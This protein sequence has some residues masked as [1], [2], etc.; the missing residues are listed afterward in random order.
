M[1]NK[2]GSLERNKIIGRENEQEILK[3]ALA[4]NHAEFIALFGRRR[5]GKSF[6]VTQYFSGKNC[7]FFYI[8]GIKNGSYKKQLRQFTNIISD[9]FYNGAELKLKN[10]WLDTFEMLT[11][12]I[13]KTP[14]DKKIV[15]FMDEFPWMVTRRSGLLEAVDYYWNRF[16]VHDRRIKLIICGS[17]ASWIINNIINNQG[18]LHNRITYQINLDVFNLKETKSYLHKSGIKLNDR[19]ITQIYMVTGG[20]PFYLSK[21]EKGISAA[22]V[23]E[24]L[25]FSKN[26]I[27]L[28]EFDNLFSSLFY[29]YNEYIKTI[30]MIAKHRYGVGQEE[31]LTTLG[32]SKAGMGGLRILDDLEKAGFIISF[33]PHFHKKKGIYYKVIDEYISFYL[34]WI[35]PIKNTL[36]VRSLEQDYWEKQQ[37]LAKWHSWA[38]YAFE[39]LCYKHLPQIR[40]ALHLNS[41][42]IPN[43]WRYA[44]RK[45]E[46]GAQIDLLFDRSDESITICEIKYSN[47][48]FAI[49]K[50]Y[51]NN[52]L[53]KIEVFKKITR[54]TK[55]IFTALIS[56]N[57]L[58]PTIYSEHLISDVVTLKDLFI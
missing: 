38:G 46:K 9:V 42:S 52:L 47:Q 25:A 5:V 22:Q 33:K 43:T 44:P 57:G 14:N 30:R 29:S 36:L 50:Q 23:I 7:I 48:P 1:K 15:I 41:S 28:N 20:V 4:S 35:E 17:S 19:Q 53:N 55:Q 11:S 26:C 21:I 6:L 49:D 13:K 45:G 39:A 31:L 2:I 16:W 27:L 56:A 32:K 12:S 34:N 24:K 51:Y 3:R 58:K 8:T 10:N 37:Y 40:K 54:T 18:G